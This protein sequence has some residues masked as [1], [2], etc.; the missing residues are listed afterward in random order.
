MKLSMKKITPEFR[1]MELLE[2]VNREAFPEDER[3]EIPEL[4]QL[5]QEERMDTLAVY[6]GN[7][8]VGFCSLVIEAPMIYVFFL[9]VDSRKRSMGYGGK[10]IALLEKTYSEYQIALDLE[11]IDESSPNLSQR[12]RRKEFYLRNGFC[13]TGYCLQY[14]GM[15]FELLVLGETFDKEKFIRLLEVKKPKN[16]PA[17]LFV[18][19]YL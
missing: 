6:D 1:D 10:I 14:N 15:L 11:L 17:K 13:E 18:R 5:A 7:D 4:L 19:N 8:F 2:E 9:A 3:I 12:K 16:V